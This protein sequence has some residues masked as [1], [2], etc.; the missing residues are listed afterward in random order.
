MLLR[1]LLSEHCRSTSV[2]ARFR[3]VDPI[4]FDQVEIN[5]NGLFSSSNS[6]VTI[7]ENGYYYVYMSVAAESGQ[8]SDSNI[9]Y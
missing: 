2:D 3:A 5:Q 8:V 9:V 4:T 6:L 1:N 7:R